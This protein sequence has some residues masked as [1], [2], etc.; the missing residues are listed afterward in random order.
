AFANVPLESLGAAGWIH[1]LAMLMLAVIAP[2]AGAAALMGNIAVPSFSDVLG[3][4]KAS[5]PARAGWVLGMSW[6]GLCGFAAE[7]ALGL[8]FDPRYRDFPFAPLGAAATPFLLLTFVGAA[9]RRRELAE[10][11]MAA[12]LAAST[13]YII[14]NEGPANWQ[15]LSLCGVFAAI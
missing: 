6:I 5:P 13:L 9:A 2:V 15:A 12:I 7:G 14:W 4:R 8:A 10:M 3:P 1:S 11:L